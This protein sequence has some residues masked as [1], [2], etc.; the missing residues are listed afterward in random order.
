M[1]KKG[2]ATQS[3]GFQGDSPEVQIVDGYFVID[4][5]TKT[6][7]QNMGVQVL[8]GADIG[9]PQNKLITMLRFRA[10]RPSLAKLKQR[11]DEIAAALPGK[12]LPPGV[13]AICD[14]ADEFR[15]KFSPTIPSLEAAR[16]AYLDYVTVDA[17]R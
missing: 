6:I 17:T 13:R 2:Y 1:Y 4:P 14:R 7:L 3:S 10:D 11:W 8:R 9:V 5:K 15:E 12:S 16:N